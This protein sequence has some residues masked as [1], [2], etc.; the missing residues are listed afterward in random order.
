VTSPPITA[1]STTRVCIRPFR[2][3][4]ISLLLS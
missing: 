4:T 2:V 3:G 1:S